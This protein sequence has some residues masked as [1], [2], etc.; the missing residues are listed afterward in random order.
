MREDAEIMGKVDEKYDLSADTKH[1]RRQGSGFTF[2][3]NMSRDK[4]LAIAMHQT[5]DL[6]LLP[7][8]HP[9]TG[10]KSSRKGGGSGDHRGLFWQR[11]HHDASRYTTFETEDYRKVPNP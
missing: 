11:M 8:P 7:A 1:W 9:P 2:E 5:V 10:S 6:S 4:S 3:R